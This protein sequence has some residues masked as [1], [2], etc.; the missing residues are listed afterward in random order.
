[1]AYIYTIVRNIEN[2]FSWMD[3][4]DYTVYELIKH[5][6]FLIPKLDRI[7]DRELMLKSAENS[8][9]AVRIIETDAMSHF[10]SLDDPKWTP[11]LDDMP[12]ALSN[13][14]ARPQ[15]KLNEEQQKKLK[16]AASA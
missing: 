3:K 5:G 13:K 10:V 9:N 1:M 15:M 4:A 6:T 11:S 8:P 16:L 2:L 14:P 7:L 12:T